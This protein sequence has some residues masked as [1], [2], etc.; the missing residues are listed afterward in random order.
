MKINKKIS[1]LFLF[2]VVIVIAFGAVGPAMAWDG[3]LPAG[4][5]DSGFLDLYN[6]EEVVD[7]VVAVVLAF[8]GGAGVAFGIGRATEIAKALTRGLSNLPLVGKFLEW[9]S[10]RGVGSV[11]TA[12]LFSYQAVYGT[13]LDLLGKFEILVNSFPSEIIKLVTMALILGT[14]IIFDGELDEKWE[15]AKDVG[16]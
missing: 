10:I 7:W 16:S 11:I 15:W 2:L 3:H 6:A 14:A 8:G 4:D 5:A 1:K 9:A 13:D 12:T